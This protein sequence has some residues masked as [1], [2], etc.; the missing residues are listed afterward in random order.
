MTTQSPEYTFDRVVRMVLGITIIV[1][2]FLLIRYLADV[3]I[4]FVAAVILAYLL[5]P[6]VTWIEKRTHRRWLAVGTT[7]IGL[8]VA[9]FLM[10]LIV[11]PLVAGQFGQFQSRLYG[12]MKDLPAGEV[13]DVGLAAASAP[14]ETIK[15]QQEK[16]FLGIEEFEDGWT[17]FAATKDAKPR[18]ERLAR[19]Y[20]HVRGTIVGDLMR[21]ADQFVES[22][23]FKTLL[24]NSVKRLAVGG[25]SIVNFAVNFA[26]SLT[27]LIVILIYLVFLLLDYNAY[28]AA[29]PTLL[30]PK[31]RADILSFLDEFDDAMRRYFRG[32]FLVA[33]SVGI[34]F[35]I[36]FT[37]I[38][39]PMA[40]P[41]G[42]FVGALNMVPYLQLVSLVPAALLAILSALDGSGSIVGS[43]A[44]VGVVYAV[45]QLF[46]DAVLVPRIMGKATGLRPV[47]ILL[48]VFIW[49]RLLGFIGLIL[50][51]PLTCLGI[52]Y[53]RRYVLTSSLATD[54]PTSGGG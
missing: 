53:Y 29:W 9:A 12:L 46:Q 2:L 10:L 8:G 39:L 14:V 45:V 13:A 25:V 43:L 24:T 44:M 48:G 49:G 16:S 1:G 18:G 17:E 7:L 15:P 47:S 3:L 38:G 41:F 27:V 26:L 21:E 11:V 32:Q 5:N 33:L 51:I 23:E 40:I 37:V 4:P 30:P 6:I 31:Y 19:L 28:H 42:L 34:L 36:G 22:D 35:S 20:D 50:A 52:A 54:S